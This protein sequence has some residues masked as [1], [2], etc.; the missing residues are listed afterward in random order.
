M[1]EA[2]GLAA[3]LVT[4]AALGVKTSASL[5]KTIDSFK[6]HKKDV[7]QLKE[8]LE[9]LNLV[10]NSLKDRLSDS[11]ENLDILKLPLLR[12]S[13][14]CIDFEATIL[15]SS[16]STEG[17]MAEFMDWAKLKYLASNISDFKNMIAGYKATISIALA[18]LNL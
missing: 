6:S 8:E 15:K 12:C 3:S 7:R 9:E 11:D 17:R 16:K 5:Y 10:L 18:D 4:L 14:A 13:Q 2:I 1:A